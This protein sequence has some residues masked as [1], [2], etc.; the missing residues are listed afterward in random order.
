MPKLVAPSSNKIITLNFIGGYYF[1]RASPEQKG[2]AARWVG[3][4][5]GSPREMIRGFVRR[6][7]KREIH[8]KISF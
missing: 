1:A 6:V 7:G 8:F 5:G 4:W 3:S 2:R